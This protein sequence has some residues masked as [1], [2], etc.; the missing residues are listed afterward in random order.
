MFDD[1]EQLALRPVLK[2]VESSGTMFLDHARYLMARILTRHCDPQFPDSIPFFLHISR[3]LHRHIHK[4]QRVLQS[5][6]RIASMRG[7]DDITEQEQDLDF[8]INGLGDALKAIE[9]DVRFLVGEASVQEGKIVGWVSKIA[10]LFLPVSLLATILSISDP[11]YTKWAILGS[12]SVPFV[13][14]SIYFMFFFKSAYI[15]TR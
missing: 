9:E 12:L 6:L 4:E 1:Q 10:T 2:I 14:I 3:S 5:T 11:G 7:G 15:S 13:L 8:L